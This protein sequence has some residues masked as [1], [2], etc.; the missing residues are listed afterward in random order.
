M[1]Q[2][3]NVVLD[4]DSVEVED[5]TAREATVSPDE[6]ARLNAEARRRIEKLREEAALKRALNDDI[7]DY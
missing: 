4:H 5:D 7:F 2:V 3:M 6:K 1:S